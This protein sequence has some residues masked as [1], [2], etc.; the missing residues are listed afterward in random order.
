[1]KNLPSIESSTKLL[2]CIGIIFFIGSFAIFLLPD[3]IDNFSKV[4]DFIGGTV[5]T[6][7]ALLGVLLFY[8]ALKSQQEALSD[9]KQSTKANIDAVKTQTTALEYQIEEFKLQRKELEETRQVFQEQS[10][11]FSVQRFENTFF[12]LLKLRSDLYDRIHCPSDNGH[13]IYG[14]EA[15]QR[16]WHNFSTASGIRFEANINVVRPLLERLV[17]RVNKNALDPYF[18]TLFHILQIFDKSTIVNKDDY[19]NLF[20][21]QLTELD[22]L[23]IF[24]IGSLDSPGNH[25]KPLI[26][27]YHVLRFLNFEKLIDSSHI[28]VY[29]DSAYVP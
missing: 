4:G 24:Y 18:S 6:L 25:W 12:S 17:F 1:M 15:Y 16:L 29:A 20:V 8:A 19:I 10:E 3:K 23:F 26:E 13:T 28:S 11:T 21:A 5:G 9:Q 22:K 27:K 14:V 2:I 7:W